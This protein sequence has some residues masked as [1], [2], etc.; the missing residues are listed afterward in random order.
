MTIIIIL[1]N[2]AIVEQELARCLADG[3]E[4]GRRYA[5]AR[6]SSCHVPHVMCLMS[7]ASCHVVSVMCHMACGVSHVPHVT[8]SQSCATWHVVSV[9]CHMA[10]GVSHVPHGMSP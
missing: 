4:F 5:A 10:C 6:Q 3:L 9:M 1:V 7:C 2:Q 8:L